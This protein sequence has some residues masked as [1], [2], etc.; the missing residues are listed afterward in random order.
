M[1]FEDQWDAIPGRKYALEI[2]EE[3]LE[4]LT[5]KERETAIRFMRFSGPKAVT[6]FRKEGFSTS[7]DTIGKWRAK[8]V[9]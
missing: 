3:F 1:S 5:E 4:G 6:A 8:H 9:V 2:L 7:T